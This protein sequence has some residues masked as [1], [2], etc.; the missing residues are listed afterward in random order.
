MGITPDYYCLEFADL[1][2]L[3]EASLGLLKINDVPDCVEVLHEQI[4]QFL[5]RYGCVDIHRP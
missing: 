2:H 3:H 1:G 5:R 4:G